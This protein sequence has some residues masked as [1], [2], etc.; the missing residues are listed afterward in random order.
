MS[1]DLVKVVID[2]NLNQDE[3]DKSKISTGDFL[4]T[5]LDGLDNPFV[6]NPELPH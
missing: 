5:Q 6:A 2:Y 4:L 1:E 3:T